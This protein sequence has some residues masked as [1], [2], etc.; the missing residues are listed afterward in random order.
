MSKFEQ[1]LD[2]L[3]VTK[4][5]T[6]KIAAQLKRRAVKAEADAQKVLD[7]FKRTMKDIDD[8]EGKQAMRLMN[9]ASTIGELAKKL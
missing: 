3:R 1:H 5:K 2:E 4:E 6:P 8:L 7:W 9:A